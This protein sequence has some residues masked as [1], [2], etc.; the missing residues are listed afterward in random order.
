MFDPIGLLF[1]V[2]PEWGYDE[3][4]P[5]NAWTFAAT[6]GNG[7][8]FSLVRVEGRSKAALPVVMTAPEWGGFNMIVGADLDE[9][10]GLGTFR[11][12]SRLE[13]LAP[14]PQAYARAYDLHEPWPDDREDVLWLRHQFAGAM[15]LR[16]WA[17]VPGRLNQ[18]QREFSPALEYDDEP[19]GDN[20]LEF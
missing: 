3:P 20:N 4:T 13:Y 10:L 14:E 9:F 8:H 2:P 7:V 18:L 1:V 11:L 15:G 12:F 5:F 17:D 16:P 19:S 6:G